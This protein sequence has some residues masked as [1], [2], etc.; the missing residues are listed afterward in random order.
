MTDV[1]YV[2]TGCDDA[3]SVD[4]VLP[5]PHVMAAATHSSCFGTPAMYGIYDLITVKGFRRSG[6]VGDSAHK[7]GYHRARN[8]LSGSDY[9]TR[10]PADQRGDGWAAAAIDIGFGPA[11]MKLVTRRLIDSMKDPNDH[12]SDCIR[13]VFGTLDGKTVTGWNVYPYANGS[14]G[15]T[16]SDSSHLWHVHTSIFREFTGNVDAMRGIASIINGEAV[17][18]MPTAKE[19]A[20][21]IAKTYPALAREIVGELFR[22]DN[23]VSAGAS[24][25][26]PKNTAWALKTFITLGFNRLDHLDRVLLPKI[27]TALSKLGAPTTPTAAPTDKSKQ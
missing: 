27:E 6:I 4:D 24:E 12:R 23:I 9:S 11:E 19:L 26:D 20:D 1:E 22:A 3:P 13:E 25:K 15:A 7:Y 21:E 5:D 10:A 18:D 2:E 14:T 17:D 16:T 8:E